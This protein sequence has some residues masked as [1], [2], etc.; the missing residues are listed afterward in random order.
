[1]KDQTCY[2]AT[3]FDLLHSR[4][5]QLSKML[6]MQQLFVRVPFPYSV[7]GTDLL[8]TGNE[9]SRP[10]LTDYYGL[11]F[12]PAATASSSSASAAAQTREAYLF[13]TGKN[14]HPVQTF[15]VASSAESDMI[16]SGNMLLQDPSAPTTTTPKNANA[17]ASGTSMYPADNRI[18][19]LP[20]TRAPTEGNRVAYLQQTHDP[21]QAAGNGNQNTQTPIQIPTLRIR[22]KRNSQPRPMLRRRRPR[23]SIQRSRLTWSS[24]TASCCASGSSAFRDLNELSGCIDLHVATPGGLSN[25]LRI[26][27]ADGQNTNG[28]SQQRKT[29]NSDPST[30]TASNISVGSINVG[31]IS[32]GVINLP[33]TTPANPPATPVA[34]PKAAAPKPVPSENPAPKADGSQDGGGAGGDASK[35]APAKKPTTDKPKPV[36]VPAS[37]K[38]TLDVACKKV[39]KV[40]YSLA[41]S[42]APEELTLIYTGKKILRQGAVRMELQFTN[43]PLLIK[44][45]GELC[46]TEWSDDSTTMHLTVRADQPQPMRPSANSC[47]R[48]GPALGFQSVRSVRW[49]SPTASGRKTTDRSLSPSMIRPLPPRK[50]PT[51]IR[52]RRQMPCPRVPRGHVRDGQVR[53]QCATP[54][55]HTR[56]RCVGMPPGNC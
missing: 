34:P 20:S 1:M 43:P 56:T 40:N 6:P 51:R 21:N 42:K 53:R 17:P 10:E 54:T 11:V 41:P 35:D 50:N 8:D 14:F 23:L 29:P 5:E 55:A 44:T 47:S 33:P 25:H 13:L 18:I 7:R 32:T 30:Q 26:P 46:F 22:I 31:S 39:D 3:D 48:F 37:F 36:P 15:V 4:V 27:L 49:C 16:E 9:E 45:D 12:L 2:R 38:A 52:Q 28:N 24:S 19:A